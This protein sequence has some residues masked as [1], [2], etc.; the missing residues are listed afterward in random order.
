MLSAHATPVLQSRILSDKQFFEN[1][2]LRNSNID[3][4]YAAAWICGEYSR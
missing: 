1:V 2:N 3:V 4:L